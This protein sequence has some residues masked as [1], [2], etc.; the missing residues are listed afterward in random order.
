MP[1]LVLAVLLAALLGAC[2]MDSDPPLANPDRW[3]SGPRGIGPQG[4]TP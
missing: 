2:V 4:E 1:K 3:V